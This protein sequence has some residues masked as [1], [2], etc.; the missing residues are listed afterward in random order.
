MA[1]LRDDARRFAPAARR[2]AVRKRPSGSFG[3]A[4]RL[5]RSSA[6]APVER[7]AQVDGLVPADAVDANW[8]SGL[9]ERR[10]RRGRGVGA[11]R[12][13]EMGRCVSRRPPAPPRRAPGRPL[14]DGPRRPGIP[15]GC[16][17]RL[18]RAREARQTR[19][20]HIDAA[21]PGSGGTIKQPHG[22]WKLA[23]PATSNVYLYA[24]V[25]STAEAQAMLPHF[26]DLYLTKGG[27]STAP[28]RARAGGKAAVCPGSSDTHLVARRRPR[29]RGAMQMRPV[30]WRTFC[31]Q[32]SR[33]ATS[34]SRCTRPRSTTSTRK[35]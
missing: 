4:L 2:R 11:D 16:F 31:V 25:A 17:A 34:R 20:P 1:P 3:P 5:A 6:R 35:A 23:S 22:P 13:P 12:V 8:Q 9:A 27:P 18:R 7:A 14:E 29:V 32:G 30:P 10:G 15:L 21:P 24:V 33:R 26:L 28:A 19:R